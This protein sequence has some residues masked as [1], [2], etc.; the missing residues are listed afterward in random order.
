MT[1]HTPIPNFTLFGEDTDLPDVVHCETI[2][3]RSRLHDWE[4]A[5][6]R[7]AR[8]HQVL[9][10]TGGAGSISL[11]GT[12][13]TLGPGNVVNVPSGIVHGYTFAENTEGMVVTFAAEMLDETLH[14]GEGLHP[15]LARPRVLSTAPDPADTITRIGAAY[16][17]RA[18]GRA[19][20]LRGLSALLLGQLAQT[21]A[22]VEQIERPAAPALLTRF[23][24]LLEAHFLKHWGVADYAKALAVSPTHLSR[25]TREA[26]GQP[27]SALIEERMIREARR[28]LVYTDLPISRI[29]YALGFEDPAYFSRVFSRATGHA[30][31]AFRQR[32]DAGAG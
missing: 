18:L 27:A 14:R 4:L 15:I 11:D 32:L 24:T 3:A 5:P 26:T 30:P 1:G 25:I 31:S 7:H 2:A 19:Q 21:L 29:A 17:S 22:R 16:A 23:Q 8:L 13:H 6:H 10:M 9:L 20:I 28:Y 12:R